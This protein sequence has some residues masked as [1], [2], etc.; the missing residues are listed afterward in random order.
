MLAYGQ[1]VEVSTPRHPVLVLDRQLRLQ[2]APLQGQT[3]LRLTLESV[4][5]LLRQTLTAGMCLT[6][7][8]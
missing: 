2:A 3:A 8:L 6:S 5:R 7:V 4:F 1:R